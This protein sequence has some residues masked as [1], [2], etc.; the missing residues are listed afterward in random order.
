[1]IE[2]EVLPDVYAPA[3]L[4]LFG[5]NDPR[6]ALEKMGELAALL[7]DVVRERKLS[8]RISGRE[9]LRAE[10]WTTLGGML[11]V[12]A[13]VTWTKPNETN[14]GYVARVEARTRDGDLVG[15]AEAECSRS[16]STWA[17]RDA[18][19]LRA[20]AQTRA[21]SRA[22]RAPLGQVVVLAGYQPAGAEEIPV[23]E[24]ET[25]APRAT[26]EQL[27]EIAALLRSLEQIDP[28]TDWKAR[29]REIIGVPGEQMTSA[30]ADNLIRQLETQL[31]ELVK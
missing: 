13:I 21:I 12:F 19:A 3:P 25:A 26:R 24:D 22:L 28:G 31:A 16:E 7:V 10:A 30:A 14:D 1:M 8:V 5:T 4:T 9:H 6:A 18:Y 27:G 2:G 15:A 17:R 29:C 11:G 23:V 20:M